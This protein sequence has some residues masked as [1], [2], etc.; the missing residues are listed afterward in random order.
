MRAIVFVLTTGCGQLFGLD[1][2]QLVDG[3]PSI[4]GPSV[5]AAPVTIT[6][7]QGDNNYQGTHDTFIDEGNPNQA[8]DTNI[9]LQWREKRWSLI[10]FD[11]LVGAGK[12]PTGARIED[13]KLT[14]V[15]EQS[16]TAADVREIAIPW[17][18]GVTCNTFGSM[19]G[20]DSSDV[21]AVLGTLSNIAGPQ[22]VQVTSTIKLAIESSAP[23][24]GWVIVASSAVTPDTK[25]T[26]SEGVEA[27]RPTLT[28]TYV[29]N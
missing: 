23:N 16:T 28:V 12:I 19:P 1:T 21:G 15:I 25:A 29:V 3:S 10:R 13:A 6:F 17:S 7:K 2:P 11:E 26:S 18:D 14:L 27:N 8:N 4:D 9:Q 24:Y 22:S 5:D 20:V